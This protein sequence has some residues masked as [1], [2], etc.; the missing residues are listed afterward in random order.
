M[1][2]PSKATTW[3]KVARIIAE[4]STCLRRAVGCV[5]V[6]EGG[7]VL[8]TGW[9]GV[10]SGEPHCNQSTG[11]SGIA[12]LMGPS[13]FVAD[14]VYGIGGPQL[15]YKYACSG[16]RAPS[17]TNLDG[18]LAAH[19]EMNAVA[20]CRSPDEIRTCYCTTTPCITCTKL[21]MSTGCQ[22]IVFSEDYPQA[23]A[24]KE[25]WLRRN[26]KIPNGFVYTWEQRS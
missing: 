23:E 22:H 2:R 16:A 13:G 4:Q 7:H 24:A 15:D 3:L 26:A 14:V 10:A 9:N 8:S 12:P 17:G 20:R 5:L 6:N 11:M 25:L 19:A 1:S 21:L 18:C